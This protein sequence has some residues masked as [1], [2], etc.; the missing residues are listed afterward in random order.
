VLYQPS[1]HNCFHFVII[2]I[3]VASKTLL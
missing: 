1:S 2:C 3:S